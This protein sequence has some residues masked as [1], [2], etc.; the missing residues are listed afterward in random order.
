MSIRTKLL[1]VC[2]FFL[3]VIASVSVFSIYQQRNLVS[4]SLAQQGQMSAIAVD[5]YDKAFMGVNYAHKSLANFLRFNALQRDPGTL[6]DAKAKSQMAKELSDLNDNITVALDR[7][8]SDKAKQI[9]RDIKTAVDSWRSRPTDTIMPATEL[10]AMNTQLTKLVDKGTSDGFNFRTKADDSVD[11]SEKTLKANLTG[12]ERSL[13]FSLAISVMLAALLSYLLTRIIVRPLRQATSIAGSLA[14]ADYRVAINTSGADEIGDLLRAMSEIKDTVADYSGQIHAIHKSEAVIEFSMDGV[15]M[16]AN[17]SFL[18]TFNYTMDEIKGKHHSLFIELA[19]R[20]AIEYAQFWDNLRRGQYEAG[21]YKRIGKG[22]KEIW[23]QGS[24]NPI[25]DPNGKPFKVVQYAADITRAKQETINAARLKLALDT[26]TS[27]MMMADANFNICY[28][29]E[30]VK[31]FLQEA[32]KDIQQDLP[33][34]S[35][36]N[37]IGANIDIFHKNPVHQRNMLERLSD[38]Y[39]TSIQVGG[40]SFNLV[41]NPIFG[42]NRERLGTVVEWQDGAAMGMS[43]AINKSQAVIEFLPSGIIVSANQNFLSAMGYTLDEIKGKHHGIFVEPAYKNSIE[44][45]Q[46]WEALNR[47]EAQTSEFKRI[48]KGG[49][50][51]WIQASYNPIMDLKNKVV[52]VVKT[53]TDVTQMVITRTENEAGMNE[54]VK[55]LTGVAAGNLT[56]KMNLEYKGTFADIKKAVNATV[57]RLYDM[58]RRIME[59]GQSVN[60][61]SGE[62][63]AGSADLAMRTEQQASSLEETAASMEEI[64]AT[65]KQNSKSATTASE[66]SSKANVVAEQGGKVVED[67][68]GAMSNIEKS[69]QKISDIIGVIEEIAFQTNLLALNAAV[70]AARAGDAGKGFA[71]VAS[72]VRALAGR[73]AVASKEIK[74]LISE[75]ASQVKT[76]AGLV[77]QAGTTLKEIVGSVKQVASIISEIAAASVEQ[78]TGIEEINSAIAQMDEATQQNAALVE[79]NSA[80][81]ASL[82]SQAKELE[83]LM[84][85]FALNDE[86]SEHET[87]ELPIVKPA[88]VSVTKSANGK[89]PAKPAAK[90]G[91]KPAIARAVGGAPKGAKVVAGKQN[92]DTDAGWEEF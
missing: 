67:A 50:E 65:V 41:A 22:N 21:E 15:V 66:L 40:R 44:Y 82:V 37:L 74:A 78:S 25:L 69:S 89:H 7:A 71:V 11:E 91:A 39:K 33:R 85:F 31:A 53:A 54:A 75:S 48:A 79:E 77:N 36:A 73:S 12:S 68:V 42:A 90:A 70:E 5:I 28:L 81:A 52:R 56:Q 51:I 26:C 20:N 14:Q 87:R 30:A 64:T 32:E 84:S 58:V 80:A 63:S 8:P 88:L 76:G 27:N 55:V 16:T 4:V 92:Y 86:G 10:D 72:E 61:A 9:A 2:S 18:K 57:D 47:G 6:H 83:N 13:E 19:Q 45:R 46:F 35:V 29:N 23:I 62:I 17:E 34:F 1:L 59:A 24:Y 43:N 49:R 38:T 60:S 3:L